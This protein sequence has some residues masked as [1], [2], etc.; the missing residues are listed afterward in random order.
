[1]TKRGG[2]P[3]TGFGVRLRVLRAQAELTQAQL[4]EKA[5]CN[6]FTIAKLERGVQEPAWPLVLA[7]AQALDVTCLEFVNEGG[8]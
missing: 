1:M 8:N 3:T 6:Q 7:L 2:W 4:A 5:G